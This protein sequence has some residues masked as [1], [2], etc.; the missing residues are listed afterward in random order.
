MA[1]LAARCFSC[2]SAKPPLALHGEWVPRSPL[3]A[4]CG[5][6]P[7]ND[8]VLVVNVADEEGAVVADAKVYVAAYRSGSVVSQITDSSGTAEVKVA[9]DRPYAITVVIPGFEP[10]SEALFLRGGCRGSSHVTL[11]VGRFVPESP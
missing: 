3:N 4:T 2:A 5:D 1:V 7:A 9:G 11:R 8:S 6:V 10:E